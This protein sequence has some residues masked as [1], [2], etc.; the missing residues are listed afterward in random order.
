VEVPENR[1]F[2]DT[3]SCNPPAICANRAGLRIAAIGNAQRAALAFLTGFRAEPPAKP[4]SNSARLRRLRGDSS[5]PR[6]IS[7]S[8][9]VVSGA[10]AYDRVPFSRFRPFI[11]LEMAACFSDAGPYDR[12]S[13]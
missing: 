5:R 3:G 9:S 2:R 1:T 7:R 8:C 12:S 6:T 13:P 10:F 4:I 11:T